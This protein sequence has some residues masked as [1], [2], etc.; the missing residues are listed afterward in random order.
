MDTPQGVW[1]H[2]LDPLQSIQ[3]GENLLNLDTWPSW[4]SSAQ[5]V[6]SSTTGL[7]LEGQRFDL[8][9]IE[10]QRLI[11]ELWLVKIIRTG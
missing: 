5:R 9:R 3:A 6:L 10:R 2:A 7:L 1:R 11:E 8:H 4:N